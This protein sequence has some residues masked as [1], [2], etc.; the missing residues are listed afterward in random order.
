MNVL[1][2][3]TREV[4]LAD[5]MGTGMLWILEIDGSV[6]TENARPFDAASD[7]L[8]LN[9]C[10]LCFHCGMDEVSV[11]R[12]GLNVVVWYVSLDDDY[13]A[14]IPRNKILAFQRSDYENV[15]GGN[16][17]LL[18]E[19]SSNDIS[20]LLPHLKLPDW[21]FGLYTTPEIP[22]D[23]FGQ[24]ILRL[25]TDAFSS[26]ELEITN[27]NCTDDE[28]ELRIGIDVPG[29]P[30]TVVRLRSANAKLWFQLVENPWIPAWFSHAETTKKLPALLA[31][32]K[33]AR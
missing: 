7:T 14:K 22:N 31:N 21:H 2:K 13:D 24:A 25:L 27:F 29:I 33:I 11:R 9:E 8:V 10:D 12:L 18:P 23:W 3:K 5:N 26:S 16:A 32:S 28:T 15:V 30:E 1:S 6:V 4:V 20:Q 19:F 17:I